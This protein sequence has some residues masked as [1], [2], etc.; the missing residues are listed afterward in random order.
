MK[1]VVI[2]VVCLMVATC[3]QKGPLTLPQDNTLNQ[4]LVVARAA[5]QAST[6]NPP[7]RA[8]YPANHV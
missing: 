5:V 1:A 3:G 7:A 6:V 4:A 2:T 8:R